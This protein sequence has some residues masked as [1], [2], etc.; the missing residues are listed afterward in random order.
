MRTADAIHVASTEIPDRF[1][2]FKIFSGDENLDNNECMSAHSEVPNTSIAPSALSHRSR[3][4]MKGGLSI[5]HVKVWL[6]AID[7]Q[8][9]SR[10]LTCGQSSVTQIVSEFSKTSLMTS[11][12]LSNLYCRGT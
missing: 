8:T 10:I 4:L 1:P 9:K 7:Q 3:L 11:A 6:A 2:Q 12:S 5:D